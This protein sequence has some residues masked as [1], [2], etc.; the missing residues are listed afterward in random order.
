HQ[1]YLSSI[2]LIAAADHSRILTAFDP[3]RFYMPY[4]EGLVRSCPK[5]EK[6]AFRQK[7]KSLRE[8]LASEWGYQFRRVEAQAPSPSYTQESLTPINNISSY[9]IAAPPPS[10]P[11]GTLPPPEGYQSYQAKQTNQY[12]MPNYSQIDPASSAK[13]KSTYSQGNYPSNSKVD[14]V[15]PYSLTGVRGGS[16]LPSYESI[17]E[18]VSKTDFIASKPVE[19]TYS[20]KVSPESITALVNQLRR[21]ALKLTV[22][23]QNSYLTELHR[24]FTELIQKRSYLVPY[25][26]ALIDLSIIT[27]NA[28]QGVFGAQLLYLVEQIYY[29]DGFDEYTRH[30]LR[31][32][33]AATGLNEGHMRAMASNPEL[34]SALRI[35]LAHF[36]EL[37]P[38]VLLSYLG[39][40]ADR[41]RQRFW[42][43][44]IEAHKETA[45]PE[46][47][48]YLSQL[49]ANNET[50]PLIRNLIS[51][52][53]RV[54][55]QERTTQR[56][57]INL[58]GA[59]LKSPFIQLRY[60][61]V[62]ALETLIIDEAL[63]HIAAAFDEKLYSDSE[64]E[65]KERLVAYLKTL[66][67]LTG[68]FSSE[69]S[70]RLLVDIALGK[71]ISFM[72][73][74]ALHQLQLQ[75]MQ[76]LASK[77]QLLSANLV[78]PIIEKIRIIT[79]PWKKLMS[80]FLGDDDMELLAMIEIVG[81][82]NTQEVK[83]LLEEVK[84]QYTNQAPGRRASE[85]LARL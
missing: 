16:N 15:D 36:D 67:S 64:L 41:Q 29:Q 26:E 28:E 38:D 57:A 76:L 52:I 61:T 2:E 51:L 84:G 33:R 13:T 50:W 19:E 59:Y 3:T 69:R 63:P 65:D 1:Y 62:T 23:E 83:D 10:Y 31:R 46:I 39:Y 24:M 6:E 49:E 5:E 44:L 34:V 48:K 58:L 27:F 66:V 85:L 71:Y 55:P 81:V 74:K 47:I 8:R 25:L 53:G 78:A 80:R 30:G 42:M 70:L 45:I 40:E 77:H 43:L 22:Q 79:N 56:Q 82:I 75:A 20:K 37:A 32:F 35:Y 11:S 17:F 4:F 68:R 60:V 73:I 21:S 12:P 14:K 7:L 18:L 72:N 9:P 54:P